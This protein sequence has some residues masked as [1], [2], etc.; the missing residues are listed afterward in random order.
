MKKVSE[1]IATLPDGI[2]ELAQENMEQHPFLQPD[3]EVSTLHSAMVGA[4][5]WSETKQG[6][7]FWRLMTAKYAPYGKED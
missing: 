1:W 3:D 7:K 5:I 4:F 2:R 6:R